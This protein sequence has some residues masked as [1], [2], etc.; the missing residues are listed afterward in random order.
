MRHAERCRKPA[1]FR[2]LSLGAA[3]T[4]TVATLGCSS[5]KGPSANDSCLVDGA[6][7]G[8]SYDITKSRMAFGSKPMMVRAGSTVQW[9]GADASLG[10]G[11]NGDEGGALAGGAPEANLPDLVPPSGVTTASYVAAYYETM[12]LPSCQV[13]PSAN[14]IPWEIGRSIQGISVAESIAQAVFDIDAQTTR[15]TLYW[16]E[17]AA[18]IVTA[19]VSF[20]TQL[21]DPSAL[22]AFK[23]KLPSYAQ[24]AGIV[25]IHHSEGADTTMFRVVVT[26]DVKLPPGY[27]G[28]TLPATSFDSSGN[29]VTVPF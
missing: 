10:I 24:G 22:A 7:P 9:I 18:D 28:D 23:M 17:I 3:L 27:D 12:G 21:S 26:Y 20:Q 14:E 4:A 8:A 19:A 25:A 1:H 13:A 5:S 11:P 29:A 16:P 15:E 6:L 2:R